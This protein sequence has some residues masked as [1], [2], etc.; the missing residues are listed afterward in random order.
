MEQN[1]M[2]SRGLVSLPGPV[3]ILCRTYAPELRYLPPKS[4]CGLVKNHPNLDQNLDQI[5]DQ[6][7]GRPWEPPRTCVGAGGIT[8]GFKGIG[9][10]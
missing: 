9:D 10:G 4:P 2:E 7:V 1:F 3:P 5:L 6:P 8:G